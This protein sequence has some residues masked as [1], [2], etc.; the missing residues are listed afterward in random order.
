MSVYTVV[1]FIQINYP[2]PQCGYTIAECYASKII[3]SLRLR[4]VST[5][6]LVQRNHIT[7]NRWKISSSFVRGTRT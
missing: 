1:Y 4:S 2:G 7:S 5:K 6:Y 3:P